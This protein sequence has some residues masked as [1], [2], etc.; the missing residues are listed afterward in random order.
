MIVAGKLNDKQV[1]KLIA[2]RAEGLSIRQLAKKYHVSTTTVQNKLKSDPELTQKVTQKKEQNAT[3]VLAYMESRKDVVCE[4]IGKALDALNGS[5]KL[6]R[7]SP[8][9][10]M[11]AVGILI[12][13]WTVLGGGRQNAIQEDALSRSLRKLGEEMK[14]DD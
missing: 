1:K 10:I 14:S 3:D 6:A 9:Q 2:D 5:D 11:T 13:K 8:M 12:D 7:A 4:I